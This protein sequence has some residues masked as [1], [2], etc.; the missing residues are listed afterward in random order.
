[1]KVCSLA[2]LLTT[3][4]L[5]APRVH[6]QVTAE[7]RIPSETIPAGGT[8]QV[9]FV[10]TEPRPITTSGTSLATDGFAIN[11]ISLFSPNGESAGFGVVRDGQLYVSAVSPTGSLGTNLD[12]PFLTV[13]MSI[14]STATPG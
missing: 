11:G 13:T 2:V 8:V 3:G 5:L 9:K 6:A 1:M 7:V 14:P 4:T 10:L 12:Y